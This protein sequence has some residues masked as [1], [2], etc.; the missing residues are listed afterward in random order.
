M[1]LLLLLLCATFY[2]FYWASV[3]DLAKLDVSKTDV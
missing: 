3:I 2:E 1:E